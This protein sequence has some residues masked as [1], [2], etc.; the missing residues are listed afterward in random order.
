LYASIQLNITGH[1]AS[2]AVGGTTVARAIRGVT[3]ADQQGT[4]KLTS[5]GKGIR[6]CRL[7]KARR[8][9]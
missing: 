5:Y 8:R 1:T 6:H 2:A 7:N 4:W 9:G 3:L